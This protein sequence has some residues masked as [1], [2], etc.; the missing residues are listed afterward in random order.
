VHALVAR[1]PCTGRDASRLLSGDRETDGFAGISV[2]RPTY[3][4]T[5]VSPRFD[6]TLGVKAC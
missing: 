5:Y 1:A 4:D 3:R 6:S 2:R